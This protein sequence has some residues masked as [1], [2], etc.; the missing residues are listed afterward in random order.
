MDEC[1]LNSRD[2][3]HG[4]GFNEEDSL[5]DRKPPT[6]MRLPVSI[7]TDVKPVRPFIP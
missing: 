2:V 7:R 3:K 1:S 5:T 6:N 4:R